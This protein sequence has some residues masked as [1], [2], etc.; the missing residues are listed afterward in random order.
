MLPLAGH[1]ATVR[2]KL[3]MKLKYRVD[4]G[5][6]PWLI[7]E[8]P[9]AITRVGVPS[10]LRNVSVLWQAL[11][12]HLPPHQPQVPIWYSIPAKSIYLFVL[13]EFFF[14]AFQSPARFLSLHRWATISQ[15]E[16]MW[17]HDK[18]ALQSTKY[19]K[20]LPATDLSKS[21]HVIPLFQPVFNQMKPFA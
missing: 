7:G 8:Y 18:V 17:P 12:D 14:F 11:Q 10:L 6:R 19:N 20:S 2:R 13:F 3:G 4:L 1:V 15:S 21:P 16:L 5:L 9:E